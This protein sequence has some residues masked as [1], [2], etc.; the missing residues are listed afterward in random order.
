MFTLR[1]YKSPTPWYKSI[2][3]KSNGIAEDDSAKYF[4]MRLDEKPT[5]KIHIDENIQ[6]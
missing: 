3:K 6:E 5:R 1:K 2:T 4:G